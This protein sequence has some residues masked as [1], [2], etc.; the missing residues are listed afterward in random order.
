MGLGLSAATVIIFSAL[1]VIS[2]DFVNTYDE[3]SRETRD[4]IDERDDLAFDR[5]G[6][7]IGIIDTD[8]TGGTLW[9]NV[10]NDGSTVIDVRGCDLLVNGTLSTDSIRWNRTGVIG[11]PG[12]D[13]WAPGETASFAIDGVSAPAR[14][15]IV[16]PNGV[17]DTSV[18]V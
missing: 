15:K 5:S 16:C 12:S 2:A 11:H 3:V 13:L 10:T 9:M 1:I 17:S 4:A 18:V 6:T 7:S 8:I 14:I